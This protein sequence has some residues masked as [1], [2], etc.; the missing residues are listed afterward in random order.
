MELKGVGKDRSDKKGKSGISLSDNFVAAVTERGVIVQKPDYLS[1]FTVDKDKIDFY[2][3]AQVLK[4]N[5]AKAE[6]NRGKH[7]TEKK[8]QKVRQR[9]FTF[10]L[11]IC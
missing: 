2:K 7:L 9:D 3:Q 5:M 6:K 8:P 11:C 10:I 4:E 1:A